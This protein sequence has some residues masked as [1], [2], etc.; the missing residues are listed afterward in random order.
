MSDASTRARGRPRR[1]ATDAAILQAAVDLVAERGVAGATV[2]AVA[3]RAGVARAT[4]YLRWPSRDALVGAATKAAVGGRRYALTD[5]IERDITAGADFIQRVV[6][7]R[8]FL[9]LLPEFVRSV[10]TN[11][12]ELDFNVFAPNRMSMAEEFARLAIVEGFDADVEPTLVFDLLFGTALGHLLATGSGPSES[13][14]RQ[15]ARVIV[16]GLRSKPS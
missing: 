7:S 5:N 3:A 2:S 16:A 6:G 11:P 4:V 10:T 12:P 9:A 13:Y 8:Q 15:A 1:P 14:L